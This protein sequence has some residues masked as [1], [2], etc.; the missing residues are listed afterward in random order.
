MAGRLL[1]RHL[2][3][4]NVSIGSVRRVTISHIR[5]ATYDAARRE[6]VVSEKADDSRGL[7]NTEEEPVRRGSETQENSLWRRFP[8]APGVEQRRPRKA[9][10][11]GGKRKSDLYQQQGSGYPSQPHDGQHKPINT[12]QD[13]HHFLQLAERSLAGPAEATALLKSSMEA[14]ESLPRK[15][16]RA[17]AASVRASL[18]LHWILGTDSKQ[19]DW[20]VDRNLAD[21]LCWHLEPE[22]KSQAA[23]DW[24]RIW[25]T[26]GS[27]RDGATMK[28]KAAG[29]RSKF[30]STT[31]DWP[32]QLIAALA[33]AKLYWSKD[34]TAD[35]AL[36]FVL[37][38]SKYAPNLL[39]RDY[40]STAVTK[41]L[42]R[43]DAKPCNP[44]L[45]EELVEF[46][47]GRCYKI[48]SDETYSI[49]LDSAVLKLF[50]P[51]KADAKPMLAICRSKQSLEVML[52]YKE[53]RR[54]L[55]ARQVLR[56]A[57]LLRLQGDQHNA[58]YLRDV[59]VRLHEGP[60]AM[61]ATLYESWKRDPKLERLHEES[62][63]TDA[64]WRDIMEDAHD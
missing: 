27:L 59:S 17:R 26:D 8:S 7:G 5:H 57:Y 13:V 45:F 34:G 1:S 25:N 48:N 56:A 20:I 4:L 52:E 40:A 53:N 61:R 44:I 39:W 60:W 49:Y 35:D 30:K 37:D 43:D 29:L 18:V 10:Q 2:R 6:L 9:R 46:D 54:L 28:P 22:E 21:P 19:W 23:Q 50:H 63:F 51:T 62:P 36:K 55:F 58:R 3:P 15:E 38:R 33:R 31:F 64:V 41:A 24:I 14:I 11:D 42:T 47:R 12:P 32:A 16:Q